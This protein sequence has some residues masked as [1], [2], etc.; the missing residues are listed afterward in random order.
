MSNGMS[1]QL[2]L[3]SLYVDCQMILGYPLSLC[4]KLRGHREIQVVAEMEVC[5]VNPVYI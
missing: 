5:A 4:V 3:T 2:D 1:Q